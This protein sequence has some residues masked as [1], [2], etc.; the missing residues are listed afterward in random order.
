FVA[1]MRREPA[2]WRFI[3]MDDEDLGDGVA[4]FS[5]LFRDLGLLFA[6]VYKALAAR[7][8]L[9]IGIPAGPLH[10]TLARGGVPTVGLWLAHHP[11]WYDEPNPDAVHL[12]GRYVRDRA[13]DR[14][15]ATTT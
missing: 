7:T 4:G 9:F 1:A 13:F 11:D 8:D 15:L 5:A 10:F 2:D 12:V 14:R 6:R 3:S